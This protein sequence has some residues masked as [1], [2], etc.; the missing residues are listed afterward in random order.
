LTLLVGRIFG[1]TGEGKVYIVKKKCVSVEKK[2]KET[3]SL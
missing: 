2:E 3:P 1:K